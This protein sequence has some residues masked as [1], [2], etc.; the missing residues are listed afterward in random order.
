MENARIH[1]TFFITFFIGK[2]LKG[3]AALGRTHR[4]HEVIRVIG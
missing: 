1:N 3:L 2:L 4:S